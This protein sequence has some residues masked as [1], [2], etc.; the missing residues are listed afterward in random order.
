[1]TARRTSKHHKQRLKRWRNIKHR[2]GMTKDQ[3]HELFKKQGKRC[4]IC[5]TTNPGKG[6]FVVDHDHVTGR[7]RGILC[8]PCNLA[9]GIFEDSTKTLARAINYLSAPSD[10]AQAPQR[11]TRC[12]EGTVPEATPDPSPQTLD[13]SEPV[14]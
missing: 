12:S 11:P 4:P 6:G 1:M 10:G 7:V 2:Y 13:A 3:Y 9:L 8:A 5:K 14:T